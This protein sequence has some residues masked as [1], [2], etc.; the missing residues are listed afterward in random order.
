LFE[1]FAGEISRTE[2]NAFG[3]R[4]YLVEKKLLL[5]GTV[6]HALEEVSDG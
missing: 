5:V 4:R 1:R 6:V 3:T 2:R